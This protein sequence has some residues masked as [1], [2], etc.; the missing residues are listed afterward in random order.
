VVTHNQALVRRTG[1]KGTEVIQRTI[2]E[3]A[4]EDRTALRLLSEFDTERNEIFFAKMAIVVEG[5]CERLLMPQ[6]LRA[7]GYDP[8]R[9]G[10]TVVNSGGK[11]KIPLFVRVAKAFTIPYVV[12]AD[13]DI[14]DIDPSRKAGGVRPTPCTLSFWKGTF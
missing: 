9:M 8:N 4:P 5:T 11:T 3:L 14:K 1:A 12:I 7:F 2:G 10:L 6:L 13:F